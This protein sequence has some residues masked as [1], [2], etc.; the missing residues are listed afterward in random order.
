MI[1]SACLVVTL[2]MS[3]TLLLMPCLTLLLLSL[4]CLLLP[5]AAKVLSA[6]QLCLPAC[7]RCGWRPR[8]YG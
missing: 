5:P 3:F 2:L 7:D 6:V 1:D 4:L 8:L